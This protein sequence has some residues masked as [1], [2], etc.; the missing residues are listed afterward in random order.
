[1]ESLLKQY[2]NRQL[3]IAVLAGKACMLLSLKHAL[4]IETLHSEYIHIREALIPLVGLD[5]EEVSQLD[6][7]LN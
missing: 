5:S 6:H 1:M 3:Q 7:M 2:N 4:T